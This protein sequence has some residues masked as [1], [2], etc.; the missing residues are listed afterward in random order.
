MGE[1]MDIRTVKVSQISLD[2][3]ITGTAP[4]NGTPYYGTPEGTTLYDR[5]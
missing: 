2:T 1:W 4:Y 5:V 3:G